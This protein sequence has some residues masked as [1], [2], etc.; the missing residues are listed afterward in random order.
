MFAC[1]INLI[2]YLRRLPGVGIYIVMVGEVFVT[3]IKFFVFCFSLFIIAF[4]F[5][6]YVLL[7]NQ[8]CHSNADATISTV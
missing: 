6:F 5:T 4:G 1:W 3:F 7:R 2:L 8:V